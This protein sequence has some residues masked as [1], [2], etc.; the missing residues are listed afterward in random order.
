MFPY[1]FQEKIFKSIKDP[2]IKISIVSILDYLYNNRTS[3]VYTVIGYFIYSFI[4]H[5]FCLDYLGIVQK[6]LSDLAYNIKFKN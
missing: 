3:V 2:L 4:D 5:L 6:Y 1:S